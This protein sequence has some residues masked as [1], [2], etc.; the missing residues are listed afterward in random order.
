MK[1]KIPEKN[2]EY[3]LIPEKE[4]EI[5]KICES[6][7]KKRE[8]FKKI[9]DFEIEKNFVIASGH[10]SIFYH[11][12]I[13]V[14][15]IFLNHL[16]KKGYKT[17]FCEHDVDSTDRIFFY[18]PNKNFKTKREFIYYNPSKIALEYIESKEIIKN[19]DSIK[20]VLERLPEGEIKERGYLFFNIF[21]KNLKKIPFYA[22]SFV[23]SRKDFEKE[24]LY[25]SILV[26]ELLTSSSFYKFFTFFFI[27]AEKILECYNEAILEYRRRYNIE[28]KIE[29]APLLE[30]KG[31]L[32]EIPF[33]LNLRERY[34]V[35]KKGENLVCDKFE[36]KLGNEKEEI[37]LKSLTLPLRPRSL[38]LSMYQKIFVC[39]L[40]YHG[41]SGKNYDEATSIFIKKL[42]N[43]E[44][45]E[46][47]VISLTL[48]LDNTQKR[49][50]PFFFYD[51][52]LIEGILNLK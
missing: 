13:W 16:T 35:Y 1:Y 34:R 3:I 22:E 52:S 41:I 32:I 18:Y 7:R 2:R 42:L 24:C 19:E 37:F 25:D 39:D 6:N 23:L 43:I 27:N 29:P 46:T 47:G 45:P 40:F 5:L 11:P 36:I 30:R 38:I 20:K 8:E 51:R 28:N 49:D 48:Y 12:G 9:F 17:K 26:S 14:K 21:L 15:N 33:F 50:F 44:P 10:Q 4:E 31:D